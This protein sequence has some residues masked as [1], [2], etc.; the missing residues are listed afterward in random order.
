M[1][2]PG[3][4]DVQSGVGETFKLYGQSVYSI[5]PDVH[6]GAFYLGKKIIAR[7]ERLQLTVDVVYKTQFKNPLLS[8]AIAP[9]TK[10]TEIILYNENGDEVDELQCLPELSVEYGAIICQ[11]LPTKPITEISVVIYYGPES[12][13]V[14]LTDGSTTM[15]TDYVP[16]NPTDVVTKG[17]ADDLIEDFTA[18]NWPLRSFS[19]TQGDQLP[20]KRTCYLDNRDYEMLILRKNNTTASYKNCT[21]TVDGFAVPNDYSTEAK[22]G[23][24]VNG[25]RAYT[26]YIKN[27]LDKTSVIWELVDSENIYNGTVDTFF[28]KNTLRLTFDLN[29]F[30]YCFDSDSPFFDICVQIWD[31]G[32]SK[33]TKTI[34]Y[35][36]EE[37]I[38]SVNQPEELSIDFI[39]ENFDSLKTKWVSGSRYFPNTN[40][41]EVYKLPLTIN[42]ENNFLKYYRSTSNIFLNLLNEDKVVISTYPLTVPKHNP[43]AGAFTIRPTIEFTTETKYLQLQAFNVLNEFMFELTR[44]LDTDTDTGDESNRVTTPA[45]DEETPVR[46]YGQIWDPTKELKDYDMRLRNDTYTISEKFKDIAAVCFVVESTDCYS[47][48]KIDIEHDGKMFIKS[49]GNTGWLDCQTLADPFK[50]PTTSKEP[51]KVNEGHYTFGKAV[52]TTPVFIRIIQANFV[53]FHSAFVE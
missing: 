30:A 45:G 38:E 23:L 1:L 18:A 34:R 40:N 32:K 20:T 7:R 8:K 3:K 2:L 39:Q 48:V 47:H 6:N 4:F 46:D 37:W 12:D 11:K 9:L 36:I 27:I 35:G 49:E 33:S 5:E 13:T 15:S 43:L 24:I 25:D 41:T 29:R 14:F 21:L 31:S 50:T 42:V 44:Q 16:T 10:S 51:C 28:W 19:I 17:Y 52:Y 22:I 53:K 26:D